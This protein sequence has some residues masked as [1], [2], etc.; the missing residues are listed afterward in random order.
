M[1]SIFAFSPVSDQSLA[2]LLSHGERFQLD[3]EPE[4]GME[5]QNKGNTSEA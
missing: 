2:F 5:L 4:Q 3:K 1:T